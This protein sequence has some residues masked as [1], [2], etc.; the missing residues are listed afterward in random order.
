M[1]KRLLSLVL[2]G[3]MTVSLVACGSS[4]KDIDSDVA[5]DETVAT[6]TETADAETAEDESEF[7]LAAYWDESEA[8]YDG[9]L[10][11]FYSLYETA[12]DA[13]T[14]SERW[15]KMAQAE[16]KLLESGV[17][18]PLYSDGGTFA[19]TRAVY[20]STDY[21][22]WGV[23]MYRYYNALLT[24][25]FVK[26]TDRDYLKNLWS[27]VRGTGTYYE[28]AK[29]YMTSQG[30]EFKDE[31]GYEYTSD[32]QTWDILAT[33]RAAD[34]RALV[35]TYVSLVEYDCEGNTVP[36]LATS[37]EESDDGLTY[38]FHLREDA[39]WFDYQGNELG[40]VTAVDFVA[41]MQHLLDCQAGLEY[42][43]GMGA[44]KIVNADEYVAG[45]VT[46][47]AEVGVKAVDEHTLE[48]T[49]AEPNSYFMTMLTYSVFAPLNR[50]YYEAQ[51][52]KFGAEFDSSADD[53]TYGLD[54]E[55]I[56][57]NGQYLVSSYAANNQ[58]VF[59]KNDKFF[60]ADAITVNKIVWYYN[61]GSDVTKTY[62]DAKEGLVVGAGLSPSTIEI[63]KADGL[64]DDYAYISDTDATT[65]N[66]WYNLNRVAKANFNDETIGV[67]TLSDDEMARTN[68]ALQN[69]NMRL[70]IS[71][72]V[73]RI[74]YNETNVGEEAASASL[75]NTYVPYNF[76]VLEED[77]TVDIN[78]TST[79]FP[80]GTLYGEI[81]QAQLDA[82][83]V[84]IKAFDPTA[85]G[86]VGSGDGY[87]GWFNLD[88]AKAYFEKAVAELAEEGIE[89]NSENP[90]VLEYPV[91]VSSET[92]LNRANVL[93]QSVESAFDGAVE[94]RLT[95]LTDIYD[96]YYAGYYAD[97]G[98]QNNYNMYDISGW[99]PDYGDPATYLN[100]MKPE[101][102][103]MIHLLGIF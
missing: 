101:D 40:N 73:D 26:K 102:G 79:T 51:G 83:N 29:E 72:A 98:Y 57:Y 17:M 62:T 80:A 55:H 58:I 77:V 48:Y 44:A 46:D 9:A 91:Y 24:T 36:S 16:A 33:Y 25:E 41:G 78:G 7:D 28:K 89:V 45:D 39:K 49:L 59:A 47:F 3:V 30:Y 69:Q 97:Y 53:Y 8:V 82:D 81:I 32:P 74:K 85:D 75:R 27:E 65:F 84:P 14:V 43:A 88:N 94:F 86:G 63:A 6:E 52:G 18:L 11:E 38:T 34:F 71:F 54:P 37:W 60:N 93:K 70:A 22:L 87:D 15:A 13:A 42:L 4:N 35:N 64:F 23:D 99:G 76:V 96:L 95:E 61:D 90:L 19:L 5:V 12:F 31:Y 2:A 10:G 50:A 20:H 67:T 56:A 21:A 103:D 92:N 68:T 66:A 100:T 1:K